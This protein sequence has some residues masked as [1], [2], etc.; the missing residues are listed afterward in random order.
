M[1]Q[2]SISIPS[3]TTTPKNCP[4]DKKTPAVERPGQPK[5]PLEHPPT[6]PQIPSQCISRPIK[7]NQYSISIPSLRPNDQKSSKK[8][9]STSRGRAP[10][11][12]FKGPPFPTKTDIA[13]AI[14]IDVIERLVLLF[15]PQEVRFHRQSGMGGIFS[16]PPKTIF[17]KFCT[18][19]RHVLGTSLRALEMQERG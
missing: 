10:C 19:L 7:T 14:L 16:N 11:E 15:A 3:R 17:W 9:E 4:Q 6:R 8:Y 2:Y 13:I 5:I 18:A 12:N 1:S